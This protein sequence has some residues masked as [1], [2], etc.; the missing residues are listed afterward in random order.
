MQYDVDGSGNIANIYFI[1][2]IHITAC[3]SSSIGGCTKNNVDNR[4]DITD[5]HLSVTVHVSYAIT[6][7]AGDISNGIFVG[8]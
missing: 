7:L 3:Q 8:G 6:E 1:I 5:V 2:T 4:R